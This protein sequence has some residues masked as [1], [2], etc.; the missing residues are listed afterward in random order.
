VVDEKYH[1]LTG[2]NLNPRAWGLE[3]ENGLLLEDKSTALQQLLNKELVEIEKHTTRVTH[4]HDIE[5]PNDY[6][7][8]PKKLL[9]R[10]RLS[11]I[12]QLLK[13]LL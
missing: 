5:Q 10:L 2:S 12:D 13:R 8:K 3:L 11:K 4:Y 1:L 6:P 7:L 9:K